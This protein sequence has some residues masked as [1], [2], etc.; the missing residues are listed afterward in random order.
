MSPHPFESEWNYRLHA[1]DVNEH[2]RRRQLL[3]SQPPRGPIRLLVGRPQRRFRRL[4][5]RTML[6]IGSRLV[7][8]PNHERA[9]SR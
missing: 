2:V 7:A 3:R 4:V 6:S 5:G 8:E 9:R 1:R